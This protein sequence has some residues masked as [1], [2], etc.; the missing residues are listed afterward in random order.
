MAIIKCGCNPPDC[1]AA[2]YQ[3]EHHGLGMRICNE[4]SKLTYRC[5]I[6]GK[7]NDPKGGGKKK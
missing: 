6:C 4:T 5:T 1:P 3:D 2:T 7:E